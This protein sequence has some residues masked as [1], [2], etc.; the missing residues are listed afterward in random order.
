MHRPT[1]LWD[2]AG[3][4]LKIL[5]IQDSLEGHFEQVHR[6]WVSL[7]SLGLLRIGPFDSGV[8]DPWNDTCDLEGSRGG[9]NNSMRPSLLWF[10]RVFFSNI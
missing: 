5:G 8:V 1:S 9:R 10:E 6:T 4:E 2:V 7:S 3:E